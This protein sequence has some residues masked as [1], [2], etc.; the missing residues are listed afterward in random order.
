MSAADINHIFI[1]RVTLADFTAET[2][3]YLSTLFD[4]GGILGGI[5]AGAIS[6][7]TGMQAFTC[8]AMLVYSVPMVGILFQFLK[9]KRNA[10]NISFRI[11]TMGDCMYENVDIPDPVFHFFLT[12]RDCI[13]L[14][15]TSRISFL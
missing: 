9:N 2:S 15:H 4:V 8:G 10:R 12:A 14:V 11:L 6:D 1:F 13:F 5:F 3:A 7:Y